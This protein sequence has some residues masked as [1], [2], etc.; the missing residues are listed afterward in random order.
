M[1]QRLPFILMVVAIWLP[2]ACPVMAVVH[3]SMEE[4]G[5]RTSMQMLHA[6]MPMP[7]VDS[8]RSEDLQTQALPCCLGAARHDASHGTEAAIISRADVSVIAPV[9]MGSD[10]VVW[11][12]GETATVVPHR[13]WPSPQKFECRSVM[14][15]E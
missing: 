2:S 5:M 11:R 6:G 15:R 9:C 3:P 10:D 12:S 14:K 4:E 8:E 1:K 13:E 7:G